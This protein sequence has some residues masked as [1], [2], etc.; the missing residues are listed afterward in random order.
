MANDYTQSTEQPY[1]PV[2]NEDLVKQL[3]GSYHKAPQAFNDNLVKQI[4]EHSQ[5]YGIA[6]D[7]NQ[8]VEE[9]KLKNLVKQV[10][11]GF[12]SGFSTFNVGDEP[13]NTWEG[14]AQSIGHLAGFVGYIPSAPLKM[15]GAKKLAQAAAS[16]KGKSIPMIAAKEVTERVG[17]V[18]KEVVEQGT[19]SRVAVTKDVS[20]FL[21]KDTPKHITEGAFNLGIASAVGSWQYG[22]SEM[23]SSGVHGAM[24]GAAF[25]GIGNLIN[26]GGAPTL[27]RDPKTNKINLTAQQKEDKALRALAGSVF[28]GLPSSMRGD[29]TPEQVYNY[30]LGGF[31]GAH[32]T[33]AV[34]NARNKFIAKMDVANRAAF[35]QKGKDIKLEDLNYVPELQ[36]GWEKLSPEVKT[37]VKEES[38]RLWGY[39][40]DSATMGYATLKEMG[41]LDELGGLEIDV[42]TGFEDAGIVKGERV[43]RR[44][45]PKKKAK[46]IATSGR[47]VG[48]DELWASELKKRGV[49]T[50]EYSFTGHE[51]MPGFSRK[52]PGKRV[53][54][55]N[56]Q[57][58]EAT[59]AV[60]NAAD[61]LGKKPPRPDKAVGK[62]IRRNYFQVK[63]ANGVYAIGKINS[64]T[65]NVE[66]GTGWAVQMAKS[67]KKP[68]YVF[69]TAQKKWN[70][71]N[72]STKSWKVVEPPK[73][74][75]RPTVIGSR[76]GKGKSIKMPEYAKRA[77]SDVLD[78]TFGKVEAVA[79]KQVEGV[80]KEQKIDLTKEQEV[81][82]AFDSVPKK[83]LELFETASETTA[84]H[85]M[86][87]VGTTSSAPRTI[88][89]RS[90]NFVERNFSDVLKK[91]KN[92]EARAD[93]LEELSIKYDDILND[94]TGK[95][96]E[97]TNFS[98]DAIKKME[99]E[100]ERTFSNDEKGEIRQH[101][102]RRN[103]DWQVKHYSISGNRLIELAD[104]N[105]Y[106]E[107]GNA[108]LQREPMK[109]IEAIFLDALKRMGEK[110]SPGKPLVVIDHFVAR[111]NGIPKEFNFQG[112]KNYLKRTFGKE[113]VE[114][115][116]Y[117]QLSASFKTLLNKGGKTW[118]KRIKDGYYY[119]GGRGDA[120]RMYFM[121]FHPE[122]PITN[123]EVNKFKKEYF[124]TK[125][126]DQA[127]VK[128]STL[129]K[130]S[131]DS[132]IKD[133]WN[134]GKHQLSRKEA[135]ELFD[136]GYISNVIYNL[137]MNGLEITP[138]NFKKTLGKGFIGN[139]VA[140][141]KRQQIWFTNGYKGDPL[142]VK[143][144]FST[145]G[146]TAE[147]K[148]S[149]ANGKWRYV[150][151]NDAKG[152]NLTKD[153]LAEK[154]VEA[155]DGAIIVREDALD[156][157][158]KD[159][160]MP[161]TGQNKSFIVSPNS[162]HG[163]F[164]G[165]YMMHV[166]TPEAARWMKKNGIHMIVPDSA[167]K[168]IGSRQMYDMEVTRNQASFSQ[169][170]KAMAPEIYELGMNEVNGVYSEKNTRHMVENQRVPKQLLTNLTPYAFS[171]IPEDVINDIF[172]ETI[173][174]R[175]KGDA[176]WNKRLTK[177][178]ENPNDI[179]LAELTKNMDKLGVPEL[180]EMMKTPG[181]EKF[182][183]EAYRH[184]LRK[185]AEAIDELIAEGEMS[186]EEGNLWRQETKEF[187]SAIDRMIH[188]EPSLPIFLHK[189]VRDYRMQAMRN[190][191]V[192][193]VT[194]PKMD[195]SFSV[196]MRPYDQ[197]I[198]KNPKFKE[199][200]KRD[201]IY[202]LDEAYRDVFVN[203]EGVIAGKK[204]M[205]L[206][207]LWDK[208]NK[209]PKVLKHLETVMMRVPM[210]SLSGAHVL[211]FKGFTGLK[212]HGV[213]LHPRVMRALGGADLDGDKAFGFM[214]WKESWK[215][216][217]KSNKMEFLDAEGR[218]S[219]NKTAPVP[220]WAAK[221]FG[222]KK[223]TTYKELLTKQF[224]NK[225][226][227]DMN[228]SKSWMYSPGHRFN[229]SQGASSG[230]FQL[231]PSV[232][233]RQVL[234]S[235]HAAL[236][237]NNESF[238]VE[239]G[240]GKK[241]IVVK[242]T[243]R[244]TKEELDYSRELMRSTIAFPSDPLDEFGLA[245]S[246][247]FF[248]LAFDSLFKS[249]SSK[250]LTSK[251]EQAVM[252]QVRYNS[253]FKDFHNMNSAY[254]GRNWAAGRRWR[255]GEI[256]DMASNIFEYAP[257]SRNTILPKMV[258][259]LAPLNWSDNVFKRLQDPASEGKP[260]NFLNLE[261][262]YKTAE[263]TALK[264]PWLKKLLGRTSFRVPYTEYIDVV[265]T[266]RLYEPQTLEKIAGNPA[267]FKKALKNTDYW[268]D[269]EWL[270]NVNLRNR[271][272]IEYRTRILEDLTR[273]AE[274]YIVND[275]MDMVSVEMLQ[276]NAKG[277][278]S[279]VISTI[280][281]FAE[282]IKRQDI[283]S[284]RKRRM[285]QY[286][287]MGD[288]AKKLVDL[289][290]KVSDK[291]G[292]NISSLS[293]QNTIDR[294][295]RDFRNGRN[296][297][298]RK[299]TEKENRFLDTMLL[300]SMNRGNVNAIESIFK[301]F[302]SN[303]PA[304]R[305]LLHSMRM[306]AA[307]SS[308]SKTGI[309]SRAVSDLVVSD[310][311]KKYSNKFQEV[312]EPPKE[313]EKN[314]IITELDESPIKKVDLGE[315]NKVE[316]NPV[317]SDVTG[318]LHLYKG[319]VSG[320]QQSLVNQLVSHF[321]HYHNSLTVDN[322]KPTAS[323]INKL[324][325]GIVGKDL[326][327]MTLEDYRVAV[328]VFNDMRSGT[329]YQQNFRKL[330]NNVPLIHKMHYNMF[331]RA[332]NEDLMRA[333]FIPLEQR[334]F[335]KNYQGEMKEGNMIKP[336]HYIERIQFFTNKASD[337]A[338]KEDEKQLNKFKDELIKTGWE[339]I[340]EGYGLHEIAVALRE[341][342]IVDYIMKNKK[343][344]NSEKAH[345]KENYETSLKESKEKFNWD[346]IKDKEFAVIRNNKS[347]KVTGRDIVND[348]QKVY[349]KRALKT[350]QWIK[351]KGWEYRNGKWRYD[352]A[353]DP[354]NEFRD[355]W[356]DD[357]R[358]Q[359]RINAKAFAEKII[360]DMKN[361]IEINK[362]YGLDG[363]RKI[364]RSLQLQSAGKY[365][366]K[367]LYKRILNQEV[368]DTKEY[369][370]EM[371]WP[372]FVM[373]K[374]QADKALMKAVEKINADTS[375]SKESR[376]KALQ[377][378][379]YRYKTMTGDWISQDITESQIFDGALKEIANN[380]PGQHMKWYENNPSTGNMQS[381]NS[382]IGGWMK[383]VGAWEMY[384]KNL[385]DTYY[386]QISQI[387]N[388]VTI[389]NFRDKFQKKWGKEV[390]GAW[391][392]FFKMYAQQAMGYP[393]VV[394]EAF[395]ND[396]N[397]NLKGTPFKWW[398]DSNVN[399]IVNNVAKKL[400]I[401][402]DTMLP[403][404]LRGFDLQDIRHWSNLEAKYQL[405]TLLAHPKSAMGN[406]YGGDSHTIASTGWRAWKNS[407]D[408]GFLKSNVN[409]KWKSWEDVD[410]F[411]VSLGVIPEYIQYEV[412]LNPQFK[413]GKWKLFFDDAMGV[414]RKDPLVKDE[415]LRSLAKKHKISDSIFNKA[416]WF[417]REPERRLRRRSFLAHYIQAREQLG[418]A[419]MP[420]DHQAI[421]AKAKQGVQATQFLYS[422][423]YR[424]MFASTALGKVMTRFQLWAWNA[425][426]FRKDVINEANKYGFRQGTQEFE[427]LKRLMV[428]D[429][430]ALSMSSV[431]TYSLFEAA[432]P[433]PW[434]WFQDTADWLFGDQKERDRAFF[435]S[436]PT[437]L[438]PLQLVTPPVLRM[439]P[440]TMR[441]ITDDDYSKL[442]GYYM[443]TMFPFGRIAR[444]VKGT[445][446]N[447]FMTVEKMTGLPYMQLGREIKE[448]RG[449]KIG[450]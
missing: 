115:K 64:K 131:R 28:Q 291:L 368:Y 278:D 249:K 392:N 376:Q 438:A 184:A 57:L 385:I 158:N 50:I 311:L 45:V 431:F 190:F 171:K 295:I 352:P 109:P 23:L 12:V 218:I 18:T 78:A 333:D 350:M 309:N 372:H 173:Q 268:A 255:M 273:K 414:L 347:T 38:A 231:G 200:N 9:V 296:K 294:N 55:T 2:Y 182:S 167:A 187:N 383:D 129:Y 4:E 118:G 220:D 406:I 88:L 239:I 424:P 314:K 154:F 328:R 132:F 183:S 354:I 119:Y 66:G 263:E 203:T 22:V 174:N 178:K 32:E 426:R 401:K 387:L 126:L 230:R 98:A 155:T 40:S 24:A 94:Y 450:L 346:V 317:E 48:S 254:F 79:P 116:Y 334:G 289:E 75:T 189:Y 172:S 84:N 253:I 170:G 410:Q 435:G 365:G 373:N 437:N 396:P 181:L 136:R 92:A 36:K 430:F 329:W 33:S 197:W 436:W 302:G 77:V 110:V 257:E 386:R 421:V 265:T 415:T 427:R 67:M 113:S 201:D 117:G 199:L 1:Q 147:E 363:M 102:N 99:K 332:V 321:K 160:G 343:L 87:D 21:L 72:E 237:R 394:P 70:Q 422:A 331:P 123:A 58:V 128:G 157:M 34:A 150:L 3:I 194:R 338:I 163:A 19:K 143:S 130:K 208:Y 206:G 313:I 90:V 186:R 233:N 107:A 356:H 73:L 287:E 442:S 434:S 47:G 432:L 336:S 335:F 41:L 152:K 54:L 196:R 419:E 325:R 310:M 214:G 307:G 10:G 236:L 441:A 156:V 209:D 140:F 103:F 369:P 393:S 412:G 125:L 175:F 280:S 248:K 96:R 374:G 290:N 83:Q 345:Y 389:E 276:A 339:S 179:E 402:Q 207:E 164:L 5:F 153:S 357:A 121:R 397:M 65:K 146:A 85:E 349:T 316:V 285:V 59:E 180:L 359:P 95:G 243:P 138:K 161:E 312:Y 62:L 298:K 300:S 13:K 15:L 104:N 89:Q 168:Q 101:I 351:G 322:S 137:E 221:E 112:Y 51:K 29:T 235:S 252:N 192:H 293:D 210:D 408:F 377:R 319:K 61:V 42:P 266:N 366:N 443:W 31:F 446:E 205:K 327:A 297:W 286:E 242:F 145:K 391:E 405:A 259:E 262:L 139:A 348:I 162:T 227:K 100:F 315:N 341:R 355:G 399:R 388:R 395:I 217:Y 416:A 384:Q 39:R 303:D 258:A 390:A 142:F 185:N 320:E 122:T 141:N 52:S 224:K 232:V 229:I 244:S 407:M 411:V 283:M 35:K 261:K 433:A 246:D 56:K 166:A 193:Q 245:S 251:Q 144:N 16:L 223:G 326:D 213:L 238:D 148:N 44:K 97:R 37:S 380:K 362:K 301:K 277:L 81:E 202:Y 7:R 428:M 423:P 358:T 195:S 176:E 304:V 127:G 256:N 226:E 225:K 177:Y 417:M 330:K 440:A 439:F 282:G 403:E 353:K 53:K 111:E 413:T 264:E 272:G 400:G 30:L 284:N 370:P 425:V 228:N 375:M 308:L 165:K 69:D 133:F 305:E 241:K 106:N 398:A 86:T 80:V 211:E 68:I 429:M 271:Q 76:F 25:R 212:G 267:Q 219:D 371:Y 323:G 240:K 418:H 191:I 169:K 404:G 135:G 27:V 337:F 63:N 93:K 274:D 420:F 188:L 275:L 364:S 60:E 114:S 74:T 382:H 279:K 26:K 292:E 216:A 91:Q 299:L 20:N 260:H 82:G 324:M 269:P 379:L 281:K 250:K 381:R 444:D 124:G 215:D 198:R 17:K 43:V 71:W 46:Y 367:E 344:S 448:E 8:D 449:D 120:E 409:P 234:L 151:I 14:I 360:S 108:K 342:P 340:P 361:G 247:K 49:E 134:T 378:I 447:P 288:S 270:A 204:R 6:F 318:L 445:I 149:I 306:E 11:S 159:F 222:F 105:P